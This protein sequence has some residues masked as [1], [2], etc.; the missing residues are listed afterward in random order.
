LVPKSRLALNRI[1][2]PGLG[3]ADFL[4]LVRSIGL[5]KVELRTDL[6]GR[7]VFDGLP[8]RQFVEMLD[9]VKV[10]SLNVLL[11][12][13]QPGRL[14]QAEREVTEL[15]ALAQ[16][17]GCP[18][19]L[20]CPHNSPNDRR[21]AA[22]RYRDSL[23]ALNRFG[24]RLRD[25]GILG[26]IEPLGFRVSSLDSLV[27]AGRLIEESHFFTVYRTVYDTFHHFL[28]PDDAERLSAS[29]DF[30]HTGLVHISGV[31]ADIAPDSYEDSHR[32]LPGPGD[33][34]ASS[35]Q[36]RFLVKRGYP[37]DVSFEPFSPSIQNL[38]A[39]ELCRA[40]AA[41]IDYLG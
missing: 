38:S 27:V 14:D 8:A 4:R 40:L 31:S 5:G 25:S 10:I 35:D 21:D 7:A 17:V 24:P 15:I 30:R 16:A 39:A 19:V 12:F 41:S 2:C 23:A 36:L 1:A 3:L 33:H 18:A 11:N 32:D 34:L 6:P 20:M 13:N 37:G 28:G 26:Y 9:E 29:Y 22:E